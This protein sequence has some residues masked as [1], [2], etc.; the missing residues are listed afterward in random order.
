MTSADWTSYTRAERDLLLTAGAVATRTHRGQMRRDKKT[1]YVTHCRAVADRLTSAVDKAVGLLHDGP[2]DK[3][4]TMDELAAELAGLEGADDVLDGV[5]T[6]TR[7][8]N[9]TYEAFIDRIVA[10]RAGRWRAAKAADCLANLSDAPTA[11]QVHRYCRA[12]LVL[13]P[14]PTTP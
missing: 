8:A 9:E 13:V 12:L 4:I 14:E 5:A 1:P 6:L 7:R 3:R 11:R 10:H 2:E